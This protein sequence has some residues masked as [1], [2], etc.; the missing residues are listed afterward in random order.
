MM[1]HS[2]EYRLCHYANYKY[3]M[4]LLLDT[5]CILLYSVIIWANQQLD[6]DCMIYN[7]NI[8]ANRIINEKIF[9]LVLGSITIII[10]A[11]RDWWILT[12]EMACL[13]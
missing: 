8:C 4:L 1:T 6:F 13:L 11:Y 10:E 3:M 5:L 9:G 12:T 7:Y 2:N